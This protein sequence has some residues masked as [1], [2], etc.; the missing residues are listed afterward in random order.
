[1]L[2]PRKKVFPLVYYSLN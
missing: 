2:F 1:M